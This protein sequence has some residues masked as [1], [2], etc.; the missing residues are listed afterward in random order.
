MMC[1]FELYNR[2]APFVVPVN[3][4]DACSILVAEAAPR[5]FVHT[6][7]LPVAIQASCV[8]QI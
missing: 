4:A 5:D 3:C 2:D 1:R 8:V 6:V 7:N